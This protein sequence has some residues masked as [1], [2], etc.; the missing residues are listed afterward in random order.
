MTQI[1][2][3]YRTI[4][5]PENKYPIKS[6]AVYPG[7]M[8]V[9]FRERKAAL[10]MFKK[11]QLAFKNKPGS[12]YKHHYLKMEISV[13]PFSFFKKAAGT[14]R[15]YSC[16]AEVAAELLQRSISRKAYRNLLAALQKRSYRTPARW[17]YDSQ[18][19][20]ERLNGNVITHYFKKSYP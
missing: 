7:G 8:Y 16:E 4:L 19:D 3:T 20:F 17:E 12:Y 10:N 2:I 14:L 5:E 1:R 6:I 9:Y 18:E 11:I 13:D 15:I